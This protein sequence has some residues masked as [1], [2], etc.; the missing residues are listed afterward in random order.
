MHACMVV[1]NELEMIVLKAR[2]I[3]RLSVIGR[4]DLTEVDERA[5]PFYVDR[6]TD[7]CL[8]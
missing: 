3:Y 1:L 7:Y 5:N 6:S 4:S 2:V 8:Q